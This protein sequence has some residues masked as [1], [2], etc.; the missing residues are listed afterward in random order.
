MRR[1]RERARLGNH[2]SERV[3]ADLH[4]ADRRQQAGL[5]YATGVVG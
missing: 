1:E 5:D 2:E 3:N 4:F